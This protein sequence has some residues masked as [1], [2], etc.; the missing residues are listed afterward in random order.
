MGR[1]VLFR[2]ELLPADLL[3]ELELAAGAE[4]LFGRLDDVE[5]GELIVAVTGDG[6]RCTVPAAHVFRLPTFEEKAEA[7]REAM[8][9]KM[10]EE[11]EM[12]AA[13]AAGDGGCSG[14]GSGGQG[15][16]GGGQG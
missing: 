5:G 9:A 16:Q 10:S 6:E 2:A 12:S 15:G 7:H 8:E 1:Q 4:W 13:Q 3:H 11:R 14:G